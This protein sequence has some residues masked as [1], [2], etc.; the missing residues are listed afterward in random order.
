V[1]V[2]ALEAAA[3]MEVVEETAT[4]PRVAA[5]PFNESAGRARARMAAIVADIERA[6][7][8]LSSAA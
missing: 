8:G 6:L 5:A 4:D 1:Q 3:A 7:G 2:G